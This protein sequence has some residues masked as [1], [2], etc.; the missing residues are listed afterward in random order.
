MHLKNRISDCSVLLE[1]FRF[2]DEN[3]YEYKISLLKFFRVLTNYRHPGKIHCTSF[4]PKISTD[5][6]TERA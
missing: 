6:L 2:W 3:D 5:I 1:T 4:H